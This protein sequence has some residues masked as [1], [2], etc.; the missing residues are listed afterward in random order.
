[1]KNKLQ[2]NNWLIALTI[3]IFAPISLGQLLRIETI[4]GG[5]Y[6]FEPLIFLFVIMNSSKI[7]PK[8]FK[9]IK[10]TG[11]TNKIIFVWISFLSL[12]GLMTTGAIVP[13]IYV[14]RYLFYGLFAFI[15]ATEMPR[16]QQKKLP[17]LVLLL[18]LF[19]AFLGMLQYMFIPDTRFLKVLGW[20]DHFYRIIGTL[21]DPNF[22]GM[23]MI[24]IFSLS[25]SLKKKITKKI[26]FFITFFLMSALAL[27]YSRSSYLA[28]IVFIVL[29]TFVSKSRSFLVMISISLVLALAVFMIAPKPG[30]E[31]IDLM[32]TSSIKSRIDNDQGIVTSDRGTLE[33]I[34]GSGFFV[35]DKNTVNDNELPDHARQPNSIIAFIYS[36]SG[37]LGLLVSSYL[38]FSF[39]RSYYKKDRYLALGLLALLIHAMFNNSVFEPILAMFWMLLVVIGEIKARN[40]C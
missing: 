25:L 32:R 38:I 26:L 9:K 35:Q 29:A 28:G 16:E 11:R 4:F 6:L 1:M 15:L 19:M 10:K 14:G 5:A 37:V 12:L 22:F 40:E 39:L 24:L 17:I 21:F 34:F 36:G 23:L 20:D 27:T 18:G 2:R 7:I 3:F 33:K 13:A 8:L 30:G 31:G